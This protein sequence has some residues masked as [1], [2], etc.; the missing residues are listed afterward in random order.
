MFE[1]LTNLFKKQKSH[2][3]RKVTPD[4]VRKYAKVTFITPARQKGEKRVTFSARQIHQGLELNSS[5]PLVCGAIDAH[6]FEEFARVKLVKRDGAKNGVSAGW[7][8]KVLP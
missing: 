4:A 8:F 1:F 6:A 2:A 7:E 5:Y 3:P